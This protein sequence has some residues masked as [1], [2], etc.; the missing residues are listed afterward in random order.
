MSERPVI[1]KPGVYELSEEDYHTDCVPGGS[2]SSTGARKLLAPSCPALFRHEQLHPKPHKKAFDFGHAAHQQVLGVGPN[3]VLI[4]ADDWRTANAQTE[5]DAAYEAGNV[6][7]LE[8]E[9]ET[10]MAMAHAIT[11]H[12]VASALFKPGTGDAEQSLFWT[13][14]DTGI[15]RRA[16][17]DWLRHR[18]EGRR[19]AVDYKTCR[20]AAPADVAKAIYDYGYHQQAAWYLDGVLSLDLADDA[21]FLFVFQEKT[22]PYLVT[23]A[24]IDAYAL[25]IAR[26]KNRHAINTYAACVETGHWPAYT[27]GVELISLPAWAENREAEEYLNVSN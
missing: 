22:A 1:T 23:V 18:G 25:Q 20:S 15:W 2:L 13:D 11:A 6:P 10:V 26:A 24:E 17:P 16:R 3:I 27:D 14:P 21:A 7:L 8:R 9:F 4:D 19:L 5:R 12:P